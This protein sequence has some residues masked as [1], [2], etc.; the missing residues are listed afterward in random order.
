VYPDTLV[1]GLLNTAAR[2]GDA[3]SFDHLRSLTISWSRY[4]YR[5]RMIEADSVDGVLGEAAEAGYLWCFLQQCGH[6]IGETWHPQHWRRIPMEAALKNLIARH[7]FLVA[8]QILGDETAGFGLDDQCLLVNLRRYDALGRP[9]FGAPGGAPVDCVKPVLQEIA[10]AADHRRRAL[11]PSADALPKRIPPHPGWNLLDASL[12]C[13][14][15]VFELGEDVE[16]NRISFSSSAS[17]G[18]SRSLEYLGSGI[19]GLGDAD[20]GL[21][22]HRNRFL[23]SVHTQVNNARRGVFLWNLESYDDVT[24]APDSFEGP[25]STVYAVAAGLKANMILHSLGMDDRTR[26]V[27]FDYSESALIVRRLL[28]E[29]WSG[30][31]FPDFARYVFRKHPHP[32]TFYQLWADLTPDAVDWKDVD[33]LWETE[34]RRWGGQAVIRE[35]WQRYRRLEHEYIVCNLLGDRSSLL[36]RVRPDSS[37]A[38]WWSNA[39]FTVFSNW[40]YTIDQ[41]RELYHAWIRELAQANPLLFLYGS[42]FNNISVNHIRAAAYAERLSIDGCDY[43][44]PLKENLCEIRF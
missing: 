9:K 17:Q 16:R 23:R 26:V 31:D 11:I 3:Q 40:L 32:Q 27:F 2:V 33:R 22:E 21:G 18:N 25:L 1:F 7:D 8:G 15:P 43:L 19:A 6:V 5:G 24:T 14:L 35:H 44:R 12:R 34:I 13:G 42:D 37:A 30:E 4:D 20:A 39:F 28:Q 10:D 38:I 29:E 41:R 36:S